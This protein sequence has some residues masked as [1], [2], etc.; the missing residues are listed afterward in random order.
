MEA[1][2]GVREDKATMKAPKCKCGEPL[3]THDEQTRKACWEC[4]GIA[5]RLNVMDDE[6]KILEWN[7]RKP[8]EY[9]PVLSAARVETS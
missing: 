8:W 4:A 5:W 2:V 6:L 7:T 9:V 3:I 1:S